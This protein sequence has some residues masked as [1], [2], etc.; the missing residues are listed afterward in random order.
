MGAALV[1]VLAMA[2]AGWPARVVGTS[3]DDYVAATDPSYSFSLESQISETGATT[4]V[5]DMTSQTWRSPSEVDRTEWEHWLTI[6]V[7]DTVTSTTAMLYIG[8]GRNGDAAPSG[9]WSSLRD[10]AT[11]TQSVVAELRMLPNEPL[12]FAD[13]T[14]PREEDEIIAYTF[15]KY[16]TTG[17]G[18]WPLLLPMV[19]SAVRAMDTVQTYLATAP[20]G[21]VTVENFVIT[22]GS[23]RGWT[24]PGSL[25]RSTPSS[26]SRGWSRSSPR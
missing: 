20:G 19:K 1:V 4:Y 14:N 3:L 16:L 18:T 7:P 26:R 2:V 22:G 23:K 9:S 6:T 12:T 13:E 17:D 25:P 15:D 24:R 8:G 5:L 11:D 21:S 10:I